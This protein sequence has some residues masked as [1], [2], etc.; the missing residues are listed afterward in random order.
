M[1]DHVAI[2]GA[3]GVGAA[4]AYASLIRGVAERISL[5]DVNGVKARAEVLD[6]NH[7][8][9]FV[10]EAT[11]DGGGDLA[12]CSGADVVVLTAGAKQ[13][14]GQPRLELAAANVAMCRELVP[15]IV[16]VAPDAILLIVTNPVD[17]LTFEATRLAGL[18]PGRVFGSGTVLDSSRLRHLLA[19]RCG[20][21]VQNVHAYIAGEH[22]DSEFALWSSATIGGVPLTD[23]ELPDRGHLG[24]DE[25]AALLGEVR[26]AA[27]QIWAIGL[28]T[29]RI[30]EAVLADERRVMPVTARLDPAQGLG[31]VC[32]SLPRV[33]SRS[34]AGAVLPTPM[35]AD[36]TA[37]LATSAQTIRGV[38]AAVAS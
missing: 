20:V 25:R 37:A 9:E 6:L 16:A 27:Y 8:V 33:V 29:A 13:Q 28:A 30:L 17:V 32:L 26:G 1:G 18:S 15:G 23:W 7:G 4:I 34:G 21:A 38:V 3:G 22:G 31:D 19:R 10:P 11:V 35:S 24:P 12:V 36:E 5:Y 2:I 14:P